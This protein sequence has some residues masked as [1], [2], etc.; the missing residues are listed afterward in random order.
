MIYGLL[1]LSRFVLVKRVPAIGVP[2]A[3]GNTQVIN[4]SKS[5][6]APSAASSLHKLDDEEI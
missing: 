3:T 6:Q 4:C 2:P 5:L 1:R